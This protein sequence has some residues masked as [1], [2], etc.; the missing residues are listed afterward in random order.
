[1]EAGPP[2]ERFAFLA[3]SGIANRFCDHWRV[4]LVRLTSGKRLSCL[5]SGESATYTGH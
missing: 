4:F 3:C 1:M 5:L 2:E